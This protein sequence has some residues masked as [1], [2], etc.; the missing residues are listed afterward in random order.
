MYIAELLQPDAL[1]VKLS[2]MAEPKPD[3]ASNTAKEK[4]MTKKQGLASLVKVEGVCTVCGFV[5]V[6]HMPKDWIQR[7]LN[8]CVSVVAHGHLDGPYTHT[9]MV[10]PAICQ[11]TGRFDWSV[12][13]VKTCNGSCNKV[14][15]HCWMDR[16]SVVVEHGVSEHIFVGW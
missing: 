11:P 14:S 1:I 12:G 3:A 13:F 8:Q 15:R 10:S 6:F 7:W 5:K 2:A 16:L 4:E 9:T